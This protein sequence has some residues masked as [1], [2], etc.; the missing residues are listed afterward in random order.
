MA[1]WL[2]VLLLKASSN[3]KS[4]VAAEGDS[5]ANSADHVRVI[6]SKEGD[7]K[8]ISHHIQLTLWPSHLGSTKGLCVRV[9]EYICTLL[10]RENRSRLI[11]QK[12]RNICTVYR[13]TTSHSCILTSHSL[14]LPKC[15]VLAC[16]KM[17]D[18]G[19]FRIDTCSTLQVERGEQDESKL[20]YTVASLLL[21]PVEC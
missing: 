7:A 19:T 17:D 15:Q 1:H 2:P 21:K 4:S 14:L 12:I 8:Q 11:D 16:I 18:E 20:S 3:S 10:F 6:C 9:Y 5:G 13:Q